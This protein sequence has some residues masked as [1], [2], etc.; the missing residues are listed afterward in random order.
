MHIH[1]DT[2][3][4]DASGRCSLTV[5]LHQNVPCSER[6]GVSAMPPGPTLG[7]PTPIF[8]IVF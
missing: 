6:N 1:R 4:A 5:A 3:P 2:S 8:F 7:R